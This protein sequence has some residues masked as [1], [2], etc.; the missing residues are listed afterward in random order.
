MWFS[1]YRHRCL[2]Y[3]NSPRSN[4]R[5]VTTHYISH[6]TVSTIRVD[7]SSLRLHAL[8]LVRQGSLWAIFVV[9]NVIQGINRRIEMSEAVV[10]LKAK[11]KIL[12][13]STRC[14]SGKVEIT[15]IVNEAG[16][17]R[18][19]F[20]LTDGTELDFSEV[21]SINQ[22]VLKTG[23]ES[24]KEVLKFAAVSFGAVFG[25][26]V[27]VDA[28]TNVP[29]IAEAV[30]LLQHAIEMGDQGM[31]EEAWRA[32]QTAR[33]NVST[34]DTIAA[35]VVETTGYVAPAVW[36]AMTLSNRLIGLVLQMKDST[37]LKIETPESCGTLLLGYF[38]AL[39]SGGNA[40]GGGAP[41]TDDG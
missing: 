22:V 39:N 7:L 25:A 1:L 35:T 26:G 31:V 21:S 9:A 20:P 24:P 19:I 38:Q 29:E 12:P 18:L 28:L 14:P 15:A 11:T 41:G 5:F 16:S 3:V 40:P 37:Y 27:V 32:L 13:V 2:L 23:W 36:G 34:L 8:C 6:L 17:A 30:K 33:E 4:Y 10:V